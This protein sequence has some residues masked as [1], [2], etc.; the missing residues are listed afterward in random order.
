MS[1][2][3]EAI[4]GAIR[5]ALG[6][7]GGE[8]VDPDDIM[9]EADALV[10][11]PGRFQPKF[12]DMTNRERFIA[13]ATSERLTATVDEVVGIGDV[14]AAVVRYLTSQNLAPSIA[15]QPVAALGELDWG[16]IDRHDTIGVD[17]PVSVTMADYAIAETG[18][19]VFTSR[20]DSPVLMNFLPLHHVIVLDGARILRH[21]EDYW[22]LSESARQPRSTNFITGTSGTADIEGQNIRGAHGPRFMHVVIFGG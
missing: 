15:L 9:R 6:S 14:P 2:A 13:R 5:R 18:T 20:A 16:T 22:S 21:P 1:A 10:G 8:R 17:E 7:D 12:D 19:L 3:R 11:D 4:L